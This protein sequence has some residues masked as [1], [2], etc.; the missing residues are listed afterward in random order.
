MR[1]KIYHRINYNIIEVF[2]VITCLEAIVNSSEWHRNWCQS[3]RNDDDDVM[4][5]LTEYERN[6]A[7]TFF[8]SIFRPKVSKGL[9][10]SLFAIL[11]LIL[12]IFRWHFCPMNENYNNLHFY[13]FFGIVWRIMVLSLDQCPFISQSARYHGFNFAMFKLKMDQ[14]RNRIFLGGKII[15][16]RMNFILLQRNFDYIQLSYKLI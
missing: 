15:H 13:L 4:L 16:E 1:T 14:T 5:H 11:H 10:F 12:N 8:L 2:N 7:L 3:T 9:C 6:P